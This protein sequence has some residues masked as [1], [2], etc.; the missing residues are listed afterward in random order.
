MKADVYNQQ[1]KIVGEIDL[2]DHI[3][4]VRWNPDLVHQALSTQLA[5]RRVKLAQV[6]GRGEVRGGGKKPWKQKGTG[7]SRQGSIR[8]PLWKGGGVTHGPTAERDFSKKINQ[9]MKQAALFSVLSRKVK[10]NELRIIDTLEMGEYK[11]RQLAALLHTVLA[12]KKQSTI[13]IASAAHKNISKAVSNIQKINSMGSK[14]LNVYD[15]M[16]H[17]NVIVEKDAIKEISEHY[18]KLNP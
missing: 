10:D 14:S 6:K 5:N 4:K 17:K 18:K 3:F 11:T 9:K 8:S 15:L 1:N 2:P 16:S 12:G 7:R 13:F